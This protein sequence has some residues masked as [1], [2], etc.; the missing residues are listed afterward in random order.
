MSQLW[1]AHEVPGEP[2]EGFGSIREK[3]RYIEMKR[4]TFGEYT[5]KVILILVVEKG[6]SQKEKS[7]RRHYD[8]NVFKMLCILHIITGKTEY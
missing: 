5:L 6:I 7:V 1:W 4:E 2:Q 3:D 8:Q